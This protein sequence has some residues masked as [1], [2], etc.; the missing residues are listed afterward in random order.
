[1]KNMELI[2]TLYNLD[3][4]Q[5]EIYR[6]SDGETMIAYLDRDWMN[7]GLRINERR[8]YTKDDA[9]KVIDWHYRKGWI[10]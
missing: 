5:V 7:E 1:M 4:E 9:E 2:E 8:I 6:T 10:F 3:D